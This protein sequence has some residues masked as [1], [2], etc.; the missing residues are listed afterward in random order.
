MSRSTRWT[1][2]VLIVVA[3]II[4]T[5]ALELREPAPSAGPARSGVDASVPGD[6]DLASLR[7]RADLPSCP[8]DGSGAGPL[9]LRA[10][11][12][13]CLADGAPVEAARAVAGR[14]VLLNLWAYWCTPCADELP[15][16]AEYQQ[17]VGDRLTVITVHQDND[18][19]AALSRLAEWGVRLPTWQDGGRRVTAALGVPN[20]VPTTVVLRADG[21]VAGILARPFASADEI[22][23][24]V[25][26]TMG[27]PQ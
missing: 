17:R 15:A 6:A 1:I 13:E 19:A 11:V 24:A 12:V 16:M 10:V 25:D 9:A 8:A 18:A 21:S 22:A 26:Q 23:A 20:V 2:A 4:V 7:R 14:T 27:A 5:L 3:A